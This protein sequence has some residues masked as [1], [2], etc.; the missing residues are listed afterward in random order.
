MLMERCARYTAEYVAQDPIADMKIRQEALRRVNDPEVLFAL[1]ME[2]GDVEF[3]EK[4][5]QFLADRDRLIRIADECDDLRV[6]WCAAWRACDDQRA[7]SIEGLAEKHVNGHAVIVL[8][9]QECYYEA[10]C[11][12][13]GQKYSF[14]SDRDSGMDHECGKKYEDFPCRPN[15]P[16]M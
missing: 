5:V 1:A 12:R 10:R 2:K 6:R 3:R 16:R 9:A 8:D 7:K 11:I 13:C 4:A 15:F 14:E